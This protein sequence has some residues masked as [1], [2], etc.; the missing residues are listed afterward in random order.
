MFMVA[1]RVIN[2]TD[3]MQPSFS[4]TFL[5]GDSSSALTN[6]S[7]ELVIYA[8]TIAFGSFAVHL[9]TADTTLKQQKVGHTADQ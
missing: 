7:R 5:A 4:P 2:N 8:G 3:I 9:H 1:R 6:P